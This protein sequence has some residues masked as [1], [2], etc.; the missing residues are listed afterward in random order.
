MKIRGVFTLAPKI[1]DS[2]LRYVYQGAAR[3]AAIQSATPVT[4]FH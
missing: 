1:T 3:S 4:P 2:Y